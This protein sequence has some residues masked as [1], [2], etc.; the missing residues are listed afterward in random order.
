MRKKTN[1]KQKKALKLSK[2]TLKNLKVKT[3]VRAGHVCTDGSGC[4]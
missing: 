1:A 4:Y 3:T 2:E